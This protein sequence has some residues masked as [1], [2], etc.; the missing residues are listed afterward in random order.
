V[1]LFRYIS[2]T[3]RQSTPVLLVMSLVTRPTIFDLLPNNSLV[4]SLLADG[5][6]VF[7]LDWGVPDAVEAE[8]TLE[9]YCD[10]YL[11]R[12]I[13]AAV[14][15]AGAA[16]ISILG[17][18]LGG[19]LAA[20]TAAARPEL[21]IRSLVLLATPI[22]FRELGPGMAM[23]F[24]RRLLVDDLLDETGN[25]PAEALVQGFKMMQ[26]AVDITTYTSLLR[27]FSDQRALQAHQALVGWSKDQIPFPGATMRQICSLFVERNELRSGTVTF[28]GCTLD[29][30][31][32]RLPVLHVTGTHDKLVPS[33]S[34][35]PLPAVL[36]GSDLTTM[37]YPVG[38]VGL[39]YGKFAIKRSVPAISNWLTTATAR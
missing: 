31:A 9:T 11:P 20:L 5:H 13:L 39:L 30:S 37:E 14:K 27:S 7:L 6:D 32:V 17:Y 19:V 10:Q 25:V 1:Q 33:A 8:N 18:C 36:T 21:P 12:A 4:R 16:G 23:L 29:L 35:N 34:S 38:H 15:E 28:S 24:R 2:D 3:E 26:P 22:D